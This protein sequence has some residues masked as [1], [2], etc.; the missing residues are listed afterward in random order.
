MSIKNI[1]IAAVAGSSMTLGACST[2]EMAENSSQSS[3]S[4]SNESARV[5]QLEREL[6]SA[7]QRAARAQ[8]E[9]SAARAA[10]DAAKRSSSSHSSGAVSNASFGGYP[11]DA[12]PGQC[13]ARLLTPSVY[14]TVSEQIVDAPSRTEMKYIPATYDFVDTPVV[15]KA[16]QKVYKV[17]PATYKTVSE[18]VMVRPAGKEV[19]VIPAQYEEYTERVLVREAYTAWKPGEGLLGTGSVSGS[20]GVLETRTTPTGEILCKVEI[21]AEYKTVTRKRLKREA[22]TVENVVP[23]KYKTVTKQ[24]VDQ[25]ARVVEQVIP[26]VTKSVRST[27]MLTPARTEKVTIPATYKT[28]EKK[29]KVSGGELEWREV[30][31]DTNTTPGVIRNVQVALKSRGFYSGPIDGVFGPA[32]LRGM[33]RFQRENGMVA[34]QLTMATV[35]ALG[36]ST[37]Q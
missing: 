20:N 37:A 12:K 26:A 1:L 28:I 7:N 23:A 35:R 33:E 4:Y 21:P 27:K 30:L 10:A 15:V 6:A 3:T 5:S 11:A 8:Q 31:C 19:K 17:V 22:Q 2:T 34:G 24:V 14:R 16:E 25:P 32:T 13:F 9:A 36:V 29:V 18:Q